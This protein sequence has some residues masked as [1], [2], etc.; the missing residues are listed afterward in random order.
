MKLTLQT[1]F[2]SSETNKKKHTIISLVFTKAYLS[3][4]NMTLYSPLK[5]CKTK[6]LYGP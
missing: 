3:N 1:N 5:E 4:F 2:M 6:Y